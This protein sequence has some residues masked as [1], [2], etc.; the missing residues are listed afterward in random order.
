MKKEELKNANQDDVNELL[1]FAI[2]EKDYVL[3]NYVLTSDD[4][5][6]K[7]NIHYEI[8]NQNPIVNAIKEN[9]EQLLLLLLNDWQGNPLCEDDQ[10]MKKL[11]DFALSKEFFN[12]AEILIHVN[13]SLNRF[14]LF[15][16][17]LGTKNKEKIN[18]YYDLIEDKNEVLLAACYHGDIDIFNKVINEKD[19]KLKFNVDLGFSY[20]IQ[21]KNTEL[22]HQYLE[23]FYENLNWNKRNYF[24]EKI[25][26]TKEKEYIKIILNHKNLI[27][28]FEINTSTD[29][30][31]FLFEESQK[32]EK[33][34]EVLEYF[35]FEHVIKIK[36]VNAVIA[37]SCRTGQFSIVKYLLTN[38]KF[39][40]QVN[41]HYNDDMFLSMAC[42]NGHINIIDYLLTSKELKENSDIKAKNNNPL[43]FAF[44]NKQIEVIK[45]LLTSNTLTEKADI[46]EKGLSNFKSAKKMGGDFL[47]FLIIEGG[48]KLNN[49]IKKELKKSEY[50][51]EKKWFELKELNKK[52]DIKLENNSNKI[53]KKINKI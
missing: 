27:D 34:K 15:N 42:A 25:V 14:D 16:Q 2:K 43:N 8:S 4:F 22:F 17:A 39:E 18:E 37:E 32:D 31:D 13:N 9:D 11:Y 1:L 26:K 49:E 47:K 41:I 29:L 50:I 7:P 20:V 30:F 6:F 35:V 45:Y 10:S 3:I 23:V 40:D 33:V 44:L 52:L 53:T 24:L 19:F 46:N 51:Q 28:K 38:K 12:I 36:N 21:S 5:L 48:L